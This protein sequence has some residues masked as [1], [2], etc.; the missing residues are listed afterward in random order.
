MHTYTA[1]KIA[2][3]RHEFMLKFLEEFYSEIK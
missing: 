1:K 3:E 2:E